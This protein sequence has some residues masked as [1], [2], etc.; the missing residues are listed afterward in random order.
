MEK[1]RIVDVIV[2]RMKDLYF[3]D[4]REFKT[5]ELFKDYFFN[6]FLPGT[7]VYED[8]PEPYDKLFDNY[9]I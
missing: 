5:E 1:I 8:H 6:D 3:F 4:G 7:F 2:F 9:N